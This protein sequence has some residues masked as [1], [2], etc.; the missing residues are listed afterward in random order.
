VFA[1]LHER[2]PDEGW[3]MA[4]HEHV[5]GA[6]VGLVGASGSWESHYTQTLART[7]ASFASGPGLLRA[8]QAAYRKARTVYVT[9]RDFPPF[10]NHRPSAAWGGA[11]A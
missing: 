10:P 5:D 11:A 1:E 8:T 6:D 4:L 7:L 3:L 9:R 2:G